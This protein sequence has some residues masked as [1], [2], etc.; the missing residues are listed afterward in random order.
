MTLR[1][2]THQQIP[3]SRFG[4]EHQFRWT[5][6]NLETDLLAV[7]APVSPPEKENIQANIC[8][9]TL[10]E[11]DTQEIIFII[12]LSFCPVPSFGYMLI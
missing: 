1:H 5:D 4:L 6:V 7:A 8:L 11:T 12:N 2:I 3:S 10:L 9:W